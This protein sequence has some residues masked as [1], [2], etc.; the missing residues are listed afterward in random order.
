MKMMR[1]KIQRKQKQREKRGSREKKKK[2]T[3]ELPKHS[4]W[5]LKINNGFSSVLLIFSSMEHIIS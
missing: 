3:K 1:M 2:K 4:A 5:P